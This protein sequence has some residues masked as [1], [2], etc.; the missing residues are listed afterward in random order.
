MAELQL[1]SMER[2][3]AGVYRDAGIDSAQELSENDLV[4]WAAEA[5][6]FIG[7]YPQYQESVDYLDVSEHRAEIPCGF[8]KLVQ[9]AYK[10][11]GGDACGCAIKIKSSD[12]STE[13]C[14]SST[15]GCGGSS[16]DPCEAVT[17][18]EDA[19]VTQT[20]QLID[21]HLT[22][23]FSITNSYWKHWKPMR[24]ASSAFSKSKTAHCDNCINISAGCDEEYNID[25][26]YIRTSFKTGKIC[27]A[28]I[29]QPL[30]DR[31]WPMIPDTVSYVEAIKRY[32][33][34]KLKYS[35]FL[36]GQIA[37]QTFMKLEDDWQW[38]C[39]Q[40]RNKANMPNTIDKMENLLAMR[41]RMFSKE[42]RYYGF[43][44]NLNQRERLTLQGKN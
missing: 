3:L 16:T 30:D 36:K 22:Y 12:G 10:T 44:G 1:V 17:M 24:L 20:Q 42:N 37:A 29:K 11:T 8:H 39:R 21:Y 25:H 15:C 6:E 19:I 34:Y 26:P 43:F 18:A 2:I 28:Y 32:I 33:I 38:Y 27:I 9:I 35:E 7:A 40:A 41:K 5:L 13:S 31:G 23:R 14:G 4:E